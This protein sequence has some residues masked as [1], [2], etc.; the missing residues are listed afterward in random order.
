MYVLVHPYVETSSSIKLKKVQQQPFSF[1]SA[2]ELRSR[3]ELLPSGPRWLM[4][5]VLVPG[6]A[7]STELTLYYRDSLELFKFLFGN[8][9][10]EGFMS[11]EPYRLYTNNRKEKRIYT[12]MMTGDWA[13]ECQV[14][15]PCI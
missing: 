3:V 11:Y 4:Q 5:N 10:Y 7:A 13:W 8:P 6:D 1:K 12:E 14:Y 15:F 2:K 9:V